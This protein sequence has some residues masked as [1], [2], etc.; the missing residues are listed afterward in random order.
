MEE[1]ELEFNLEQA[2]RIQNGEEKGRIV[3]KLG[4]NVRIICIN[5]KGEFPIIGLISGMDSPY[6]I[7]Y[8]FTKRGEF[9]STLEKNNKYN[10]ILKIPMTSSFDLKPFDKVLVRDNETD[11]WSIDLFSNYMYNK[12]DLIVAKCM[13]ATWNE[14]IPYNDDTKHLIGTTKPFKY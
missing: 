5:A 4:Y 14:C 8:S 3:N 1:L 2:L 6:E 9:L 11:K 12:R 13:Y 10:L 7:P